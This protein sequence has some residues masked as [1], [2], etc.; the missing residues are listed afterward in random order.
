[1]AHFLPCG[2][3]SELCADPSMLPATVEPLAEGD[4]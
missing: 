3:R 1:M 2:V 4:A